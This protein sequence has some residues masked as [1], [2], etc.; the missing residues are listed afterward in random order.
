[1]RVLASIS[2]GKDSVAA[3][4]A[5][6]ENGGQCDG[7][8]YCRVMFDE[9]TSAEF[10]EHEDFL[11]NKLFPTLEREYG[12]K[13]EIVQGKESYKAHFYRK[14]KRG[15]KTGQ[16]YGFPSLWCP[17][18]NSDLKIAPMS[19]FKKKQGEYVS[20]VGIAADETKRIERKTV[21]G[22]ILPLVE[23]GI[24]ERGAYELCKMRGLLSPGYEGGRTRLGCW[25]CHNQRIEE[26]R[27][28]YFNYPELW[29]KLTPLDKD[30]PIKF[31]PRRTLADFKRRFDSEG[32]QMSLDCEG[33]C[34]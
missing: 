15:V 1:M 16:I 21:S 5:H 23:R 32:Y 12:I 30:S 7:A 34:K 27:Q 20:V 14:F 18:C 19:A 9:E 11:Y 26:M 25:F 8:I 13:T 2:G 33:V 6:M 3:L 22:K 29:K 24:T 28:L 31:T 17:W 10:P 4:I